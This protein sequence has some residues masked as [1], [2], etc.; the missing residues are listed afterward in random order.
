M[1]QYLK[2][3]GEDK[4]ITPNNEK[5]LRNY[6]IGIMEISTVLPAKSDSDVVFC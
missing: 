1:K 2:I 3:F 6:G 5:L 4:E